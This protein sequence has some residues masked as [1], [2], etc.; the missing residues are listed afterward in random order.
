MRG[1]CFI[2]LFAL[3]GVAHADDALWKRLQTEPNLVVLMRH[4]R[5]D[6]Q[7]PM[8]WDAT[9]QCRGERMLT[10][11]GR[12]YARRLGELFRKHGITPVVISSPMC[13]ARE[14]ARLA[15]GEGVSDPDLREIGSAEADRK[16]IFRE[17]AARLLQKHR[18]T[19]PVVFVSHR[20]NIDALALER[21]A[22]DEL[23]VG[24]IGADGEV[25]VIGRMRPLPGAPADTASP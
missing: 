22:T 18:G 5:A 10:D 20:P 13:R 14:T 21:I 16:R 24:R 7:N 17:M 23:L 25:D 19:R 1:I 9:G 3:S 8:T 11:E 6:A 2:L 12:S 4:A 15:F